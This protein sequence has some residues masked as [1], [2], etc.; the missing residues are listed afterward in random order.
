MKEESL[1]ILEELGVKVFLPEKGVEGDL[2]WSCLAGY[3]KEKREIEDT[4]LLG[5]TYP[6]IY[7]QISS[8]TRMKQESNRAKAVLFEG[9]PGCGKTT[10]AK[11]IA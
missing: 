9:P 8:G 5:L 11:I 3:S 7:S 10:S 4:I 1:K 6:E 2:D